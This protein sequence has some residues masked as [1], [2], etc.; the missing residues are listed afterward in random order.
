MAQMKISA[1]IVLVAFSIQEHCWEDLQDS[2]TSKR[3]NI[4]KE[5]K[6]ADK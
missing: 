6:L 4:P 1:P 2:D 5:I 3:K